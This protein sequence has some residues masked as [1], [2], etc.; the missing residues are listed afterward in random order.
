PRY[1][2]EDARADR[3]EFRIEEHR[4]I[5]VELDLGAVIAAHAVPGTYHHGVVDLALLHPPA[6]RRILDA[7]LDDI[8]DVG[9][10]ALA[11]AEHLDTH[12]PPSAGV[13]GDIQHRLHLDHC[14]LSNLTRDDSARCRLTGTCKRRLKFFSAVSCARRPVLEPVRVMPRPTDFLPIPR[15]R[16]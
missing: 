12:H 3:L 13:I 1:R 15:P 8:A 6:R 4:R 9:I 14:D 16:R 2:S 5:G 10:T 11:A 7:H